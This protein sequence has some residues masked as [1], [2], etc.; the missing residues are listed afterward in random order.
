[1]TS[2]GQVPHSTRLRSPSTSLQFP[3]NH[4]LAFILCSSRCSSELDRVLTV[5]L[6]ETLT[7]ISLKHT[8]PG[9]QKDECGWIHNIFARKL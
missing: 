8:M 3:V 2:I 5:V 7:S 4:E 6:L 9:K 1:M